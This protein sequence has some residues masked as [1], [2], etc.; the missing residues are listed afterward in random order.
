[1]P[2]AISDS[3]RRASRNLLIYEIFSA[4]F[5]RVNGCSSNSLNCI[6]HFEPASYLLQDH[7]REEAS[8]TRIHAPSLTTDTRRTRRY[9]Q[10]AFGTSEVKK[11]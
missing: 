5:R 8:Y 10:N 3:T 4:D 7:L 1:V 11:L 6:Q 2:S 9:T